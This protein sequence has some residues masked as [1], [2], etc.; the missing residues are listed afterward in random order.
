MNKLKEKMTEK[1]MHRYLQLGLPIKEGMSK[2]QEYKNVV[3][4]GQKP[5]EYT[6][7]FIG[8]D[9][10]QVYRVDTPAGEAEILYFA[11]RE[12]F[13]RA[14]RCL[15]YKCEN[16]AIP[17]SMGAMTIAG[18]INWEKI[19]K[20]KEAYLQSG[21]TDWQAE[22]K[23]FTSIPGNYKDRLVLVSKGGYSGLSAKDL[24]YDRTEWEKLSLEIRIYH[25]LCHVVCR[26][27]FPEKKNA[28]Q[29][30]IVADAFG[31][32]KAKG[33]YDTDLARKCLGIWDGI[34]REGG[35]LENYMQEGENPEKYM[36]YVKKTI[37]DI[38]KFL[39]QVSE[40]PYWER[41]ILLEKN[42]PGKG[43]TVHNRR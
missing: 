24:E 11:V 8:S 5:V 38:E 37:V 17:A 2:S 29:D 31:I 39:N 13:E 34:Y 32:L 15:A 36:E 6:D 30:E 12:D 23:R 4:R 7:F 19:R 41:L 28:V 21:K 14:V 10:D 20:H 27:L 3:L 33:Y 25:E 26:T 43:K 16:R 9:Q 40:E 18:I 42:L 22:F 35:R 1:Y